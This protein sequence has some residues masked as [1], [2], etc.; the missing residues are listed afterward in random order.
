MRDGLAGKDVDWKTAKPPF[1]PEWRL[2]GR[3]AADDKSSITAFLTA[4]D[5]LKALHRTPSVNIK[6]VWEGEEEA[7]SVAS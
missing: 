2:F 4:F 3:A 6:V 1:N 7:N 5:A